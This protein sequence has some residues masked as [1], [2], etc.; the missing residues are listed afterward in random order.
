MIENLKVNR[1]KPQEIMLKK[2]Q[3]PNLIGK[4]FKQSMDL[5]YV[6]PSTSE[7]RIVI[8]HLGLLIE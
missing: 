4:N 5:I 2:I 8:R 7:F 6:S 1:N 3:I